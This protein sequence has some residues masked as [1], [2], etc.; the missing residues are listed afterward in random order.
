MLQNI[1][2]SNKF[3][4]FKLSMLHN[5]VKNKIVPQKNTKQQKHFC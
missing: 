1:Y 4:S 2:I 5:I 3:S